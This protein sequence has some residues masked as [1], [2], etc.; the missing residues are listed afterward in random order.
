M[1]SEVG[2]RP[3][4]TLTVGGLLVTGELIDGET[5]FSEM[6]EAVAEELPS[7]PVAS[8]LEALLA[9]FAAKVATPGSDSSAAGEP[10]HVHIRG[11]RVF[12]P[13][14]AALPAVG[15]ASWRVRLT[16]VDAV[17]LNLATPARARTE[18]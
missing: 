13:S 15:G 18:V 10:L 4:V 6:S 7:G 14:G 3:M 9:E 8:T 11:A 17:S 16:A 12:D 2:V 5:Y 1:S